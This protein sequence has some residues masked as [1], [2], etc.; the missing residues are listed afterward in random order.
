MLRQSTQAGFEG[1]V[2]M[3][4]VLPPSPL[5]QLL[6]HAF[7]VIGTRHRIDDGI[8]SNW[9]RVGLLPCIALPLHSSYILRS[10]ARRGRNG[11]TQVWGR[12]AAPY[13]LPPLPMATQSQ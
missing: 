12:V 13:P 11:S 5:R 10:Q 1:L 6:R 3:G 2:T 7:P 9:D 4:P 8:L